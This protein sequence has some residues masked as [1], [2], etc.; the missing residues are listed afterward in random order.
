MAPA[1]GPRDLLSPAALHILMAIAE[2]PVHGHGIR[3]AIEDRTAG[4]LVLGPG[5]LY[6][7]I[8]RM[9]SDGWLENAPEAADR[10]GDGRR[11]YYRITAAGR[12][13]MEAELVRLDRLVADA[14]A[15]RLLP[16][17]R[18]A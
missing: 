14:R 1:S 12:R 17:G 5:T 4:G 9:Q 3:E 18:C 16:L 15:R 7:A 6:E 8:H 13:A 11:K 2:G 10:D